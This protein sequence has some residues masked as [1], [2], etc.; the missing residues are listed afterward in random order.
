[1]ARKKGRFGDRLIA[2]ATWMLRDAQGKAAPARRTIVLIPDVKKIRRKLN[3]SQSEFARRF[4]LNARTIQ[5]W[6]QGR[7]VPDQPA[8]VLLTLIE[9]A[10]KTIE[11]LVKRTL[12]GLNTKV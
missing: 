6:E 4:H 9:Q 7:T 11:K 12:T 8:R 10:P 1:M 5:H 3:V 2:A